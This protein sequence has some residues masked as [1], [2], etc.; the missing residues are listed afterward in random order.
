MLLIL[1]VFAVFSAWLMT[2]IQPLC[3]LVVNLMFKLQ[4]FAA[5]GFILWHS[6][7]FTEDK[8]Q[9]SCCCQVFLKVF[10]FPPGVCFSLD[11]QLH[12]WIFHNFIV[13]LW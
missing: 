11:A 5:R 6:A 9:C 3:L 1:S 7:R 8:N 10:F 2:M 4:E 13:T 12:L